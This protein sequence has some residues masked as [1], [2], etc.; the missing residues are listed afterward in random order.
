[1]SHE[2]PELFRGDGR[3]N[4]QP[5][6]FLPNTRPRTIKRSTARWIIDGF[7]HR[8]QSSHGPGATLW[9][10]VHYCQDR[11]ISYEMTAH[12][13]LGYHVRKIERI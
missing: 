1:M 9:V 11:R 3:Q 10:I 7:E 12:P 5:T 2:Y 6:I 13:G 4:V 8:G